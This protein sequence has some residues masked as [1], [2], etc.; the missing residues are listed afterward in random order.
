MK[1]TNIIMILMDDMGWT[2]LG[3]TGSSFYETPQID[4]LCRQGMR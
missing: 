2:D 3:C 1:K 4:A